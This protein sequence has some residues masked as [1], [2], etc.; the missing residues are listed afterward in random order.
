M[1]TPWSGVCDDA[2]NVPTTTYTQPNPAAWPAIDWP[3]AI[4]WARAKYL[5]LAGAVL[6]ALAF[7]LSALAAYGLSE[8]EI[9]KLHAVE[10]YRAGRFTANAEHPMLMK[11][12]M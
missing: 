9:N 3:F 5:A 2:A 4:S 8:D 1:C 11:V 7:R 6:L 12:A 10:E